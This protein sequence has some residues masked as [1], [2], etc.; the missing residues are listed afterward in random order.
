M[1]GVIGLDI[2]GAN[3]KASDG[4]H[5]S[6]SVPFHLWK[7]PERLPAALQELLDRFDR[8]D[9]IVVTMTGELSDCYAT[10]SEGVT[11]I[12]AA[13]TH[14]AAGRPVGVWQTAGEFVDTEVAREFWMLTAA[15]NWHALA[16]WAGRIAPSGAALLIDIGS[17]TTDII[18]LIDGLPLPSGRTDLE[19]LQSGELVYT[20]VKR[21][22][23]CAIASCVPFR[24]SPIPLAT[25]LF[26]T[27]YDMYLLT[28]EL[29]EDDADTG[30]A[31]GRSA[32]MAHARDR[33][34]RMLCA[35]RTELTSDEIADIAS[36]LRAT[37]CQRLGEA[38]KSV[39][40]R[41]QGLCVSVLTSGEGEFLARQLVADTPAL[42]NATFLSLAEMLG[43]EHSR[44]ACAYALARLG[45]ER[46]VV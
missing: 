9:G 22:P 40:H 35:D 20:G 39:L 26:A 32:T 33:L 19:R 29:P 3:L 21:T 23:A 12:L 34:G 11:D 44:A 17:T 14:A 25:E 5:R 43:P 16:T 36:N 24:G 18:P 4:E 7:Q 8:C 45:S 10:K 31:D 6:L 37:H 30:T 27:T 1:K 28:G 15:A 13:V 2:G 41:H 46:L 38:L 42:K